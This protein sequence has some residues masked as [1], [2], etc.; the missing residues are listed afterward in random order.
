MTGKAAPDPLGGLLAGIDLLIFDKDGTLI[1]FH[2][3]WAGWIGA[4]AT[5]L[6][7]ATRRPLRGGLYGLLGVDSDTG[8]VQAHGLLAATP[9]ARIRELVVGY[10]VTAGVSP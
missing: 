6:E 10:V 4:L 5:R 9:M 2:L 1:D 7:Q 3:M 8:L